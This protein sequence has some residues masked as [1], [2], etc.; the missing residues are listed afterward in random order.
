M[1]SDVA[2]L[3]QH[4]ENLV[5]KIGQ[6]MNENKREAIMI[7]LL[8]QEMEDRKR[9]V[10]EVRKKQESFHLVEDQLELI[11]GVISEEEALFL[12]KK[13]E[14]KENVKNVVSERELL[15][16]E[17]R[18][19]LVEAEAELREMQVRIE[20]NELKRQNLD[21][22]I[23]LKS[24]KIEKILIDIEHENKLLKEL[25]EAVLQRVEDEAVIKR[26]EELV[27]QRDT[28]LK[29]LSRQKDKKRALQEKMDLINKSLEK[30]EADLKVAREARQQKVDEVHFMDKKREDTTL[31]A[32][33]LQQELA[34][35]QELDSEITR[36][37]YYVS[38]A[39]L[40]LMEFRRDH[41]DK[42]PKTGDRSRL[43]LLQSE[44]MSLPVSTY[45][46]TGKDRI[47][48]SVKTIIDKIKNINLK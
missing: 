28:K 4:F 18:Q 46:N 43:Q 14:E 44:L 29:E 40:K 47:D 11:K 5:K 38:K 42:F 10:E 8:L 17:K 25:N 24:Q 45:S 39:E 26:H 30:I 20:E 37:N 22:K 27:I 12:V 16:E 1:E 9:E 36:I 21:K 23:E 6:S 13:K 34:E 2:S 15:L 3:E 7:H 33:R 35:L 41:R 31:S 19:V 32:Q 48:S